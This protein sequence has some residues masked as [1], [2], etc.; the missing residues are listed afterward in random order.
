MGV[1]KKVV[2]QFVPPLLLRELKRRCQMA[3]FRVRC[4]EGADKPK[5]DFKEIEALNKREAAEK[6]CGEP[7]S[8]RGSPARLRAVVW[9]KLPPNKSFYE[10]VQE[11]S[12]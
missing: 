9:S 10:K 4:F 12:N 8:E 6:A 3:R 2:G 11:N 5:G 1:E 7:L